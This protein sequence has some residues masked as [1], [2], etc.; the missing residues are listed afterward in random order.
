MSYKQDEVNEDGWCEWFATPA[1]R[2]AC[3]DCKLVHDIELRVRKRKVQMR[4]KRNP[5]ST[6]ALRRPKPTRIHLL[7]AA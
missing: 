1:L 7:R 3:C 5:R 6:A 2:I 4:I